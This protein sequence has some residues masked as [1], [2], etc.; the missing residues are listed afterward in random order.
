MHGVLHARVGVPNLIGIA[1]PASI[2]MEV[3]FTPSHATD[4]ASLAV[5][6]LLLISIV[7]P[8]VAVRTEVGPQDGFAINA[9][10]GSWLHNETQ[11]ADHL[12]DA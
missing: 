8:Q 5:E 9:L 4:P 2:T 10:S 12:C 6:N 7:V 11:L 1:R 3:V